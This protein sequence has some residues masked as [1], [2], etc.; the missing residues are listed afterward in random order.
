MLGVLVEGD[1][2]PE[3]QRDFLGDFFRA[4][5][6]DGELMVAFGPDGETVDGRWH[7]VVHEHQN[8]TRP[9]VK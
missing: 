2:P 8:H 3:L 1:A 5:A 9:F 7:R 4:D 6:G